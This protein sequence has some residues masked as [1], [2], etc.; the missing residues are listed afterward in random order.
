MSLYH[1]IIRNFANRYFLKPHNGIQS[2][3]GALR[4]ATQVA[5]LD[6]S[7]NRGLAIIEKQSKVRYSRTASLEDKRPSIMNKML[8][9]MKALVVTTPA[10]V[11]A[12]E[13]RCTTCGT[14]PSN[15]NTTPEG[16]ARASNNSKRTIL[17]HRCH[18]ILLLTMMFNEPL[19]EKE[20][21]VTKGKVSTESQDNPTSPVYPKI[22]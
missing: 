4:S 13:E 21:E 8:N 16:E 3:Q 5:I 22:S 14:L 18:N 17:T 2:D 20:T 15:T 9:E 12:V 7:L 6:K 10:P 1:G 19:T 11:K